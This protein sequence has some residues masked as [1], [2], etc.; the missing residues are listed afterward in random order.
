MAAYGLYSHIQ[1][2]KR[3]SVALLIGLFFLV[4]VMVFAG[5]LLAEGLSSYYENNAP[6]DYLIHAALFDFVKAFPFATIGAIIWIA[7]AYKFHQ[8]MIDAV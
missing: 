8:K 3:R 2:N 1:S 4:Y 6:I 5:A 7:I